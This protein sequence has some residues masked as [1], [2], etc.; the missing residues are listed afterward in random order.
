MELHNVPFFPQ[1]QV[2]KYRSNTNQC[3]QTL[4]GKNEHIKGAGFWPTLFW[5]L[6]GMWFV[7]SLPELLMERIVV[8]V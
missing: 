6:S 1:D 2:A 7:T 4:I 5:I 8:F 3:I